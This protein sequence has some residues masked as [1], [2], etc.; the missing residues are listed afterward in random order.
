MSQQEFENFEPQHAE[1]QQAEAAYY[2]KQEQLMSEAP[3]W[4]RY[5]GAYDH[6]KVS[7]KPEASHS[8]QPSL[9]TPVVRFALA[10]F[11]SG[12]LFGFTLA[13]FALSPHTLSLPQVSMPPVSL[14]HLGGGQDGSASTS[15]II[16]QQSFPV[17]GAVQLSIQ[18]HAAGSIRIHTGDTDHV[19]VSET[20][21]S[22]SVLNNLPVQSMQQ[23]NALT[24]SIDNAGDSGVVL[25]VTT[26]ADTSLN[27][28]ADS[29]SINF[30]GSFDP[31]GS[32]QFASQ[33]GSITISVPAD[34]AFQLSN[35][36]DTG[37][38]TNA[39]GSDLTGSD[40]RAD[41]AIIAN[42]GGSITIQQS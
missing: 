34:S 12:T 20:T 16:P 33:T 4:G 40:P 28:T 8:Q 30:D 17:S 41:V 24:L 6:H 29:A 26:P 31:H 21:Q 25:D 3:P 27:V 7:E 36:V 2:R 22:G 5:H 13:T 39:F 11:I 18:D 9:W 19:L 23:G 14:P 35:V 37:D 15:S 10:L 1:G 42:E 32:Y 38:F